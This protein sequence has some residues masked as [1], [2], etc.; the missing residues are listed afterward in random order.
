VGAA[1]AGG[2]LVW[3][4]IRGAS[5]S[6]SLK[7]LISGQ[8][9]S[10]ADVNPVGTPAGG[11]TAA[12]AGGTAAGAGGIAGDALKYE[13]HAYLFGGAPGLD[14]TRPWDC[15]SFANWVVG[16]DARMAIPGFAPGKYTGAVHG[17]STISWLAWSGCRTVGHD[18]NQAQAGDLAVWQTHMGIC[19]GPNAMISAQNPG[20][21]TRTSVIDGF[22]RGEILFVRRL[23]A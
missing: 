14:G 11:G 21:G 4:G 19:T 7:S 18:G 6:A 8:A 15:S 10:G 13:G 1:A 3:S 12:A 22:I 16:H 17:P 2:I 9:P 23:V 5:L 20:S